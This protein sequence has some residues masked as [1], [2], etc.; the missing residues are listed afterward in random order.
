M[1]KLVIE[2]GLFNEL[3]DAI[4]ALGLKIEDVRG[5]GYDNGSNMKGKHQG[6]QKRLLEINPR[7]L[8]MSCACH[9]LNLT[10]SDMAHS[11]IKAVSFFGVMQRIYALFSSSPKRWKKVTLDSRLRP[12]VTLVSNSPNRQSS[13]LDC[14]SPTATEH[15]PPPTAASSAAA[16]S[17]SNSQRRRRPQPTPPS[18]S[19]CRLAVSHSP[20]RQSALCSP[21]LR[22]PSTARSEKLK[23]RWNQ[24]K[25]MLL[26]QIRWLCMFN[27]GDEGDDMNE[28]ELNDG[29]STVKL[30]MIN[31]EFMMTYV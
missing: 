6:V 10:V 17:R 21:S 27:K 31:Y 1:E 23:I 11:C 13:S 7:A 2:Y 3:L 22:L 29:M 16:R 24:I 20:L 15:W 18:L 14:D 30:C 28:D 12:L 26:L 4:K 9:S 8:Y 19:G 25:V 5:Q